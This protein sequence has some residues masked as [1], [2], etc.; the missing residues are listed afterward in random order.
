MMSPREGV[1]IEK[2]RGTRVAKSIKLST[3]DF[4]SGHD[5][6]VGE[7]ELHM[8]LC[9]DSVKPAWDSLSPSLSLCPSHVLSLSLSLKINFKKRERE[10]RAKA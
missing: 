3:V 4:Y 10:K 5:L 9:T 8:G 7:F 6:T 1:L 2:R